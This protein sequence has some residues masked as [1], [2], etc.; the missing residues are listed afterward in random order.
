VEALQEICILKYF[1]K[2]EE[3]GGVA[4]SEHGFLVFMWAG[5]KEN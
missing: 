1:K 2:H 5:E 4:S 3:F